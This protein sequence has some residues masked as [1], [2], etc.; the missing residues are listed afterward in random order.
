LPHTRNVEAS[1]HGTFD[2]SGESRNRFDRSW[3]VG[4]FAVPALFAIALVGLAMTQPAA[5]NWI[6]EAA[7]AEFAGAFM[8]PEI[9]PTQL[10]QPAMQIRSVRAD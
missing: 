9:A 1:M 8:V 7:Q 4:L 6:S 10:A 2:R 3:S 5:S